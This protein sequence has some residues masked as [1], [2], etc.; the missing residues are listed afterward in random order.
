M[1]K[2]K[3]WIRT[4]AFRSL[5]KKNKNKTKNLEASRQNS[6]FFNGNLMDET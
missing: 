4:I 2:N 5:S 1:F 6:I 3:N